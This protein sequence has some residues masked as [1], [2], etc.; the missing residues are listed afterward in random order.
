MKETMASLQFWRSRPPL[1][2]RLDA[3]AGNIALSE[4]IKAHIRAGK[5]FLGICLGLQLLFTRSYEDGVYEGLDLF[6]GEVV[7]FHNTVRIAADLS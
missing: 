6:P 3:E 7:R 2:R 4:P 1:S 5:P